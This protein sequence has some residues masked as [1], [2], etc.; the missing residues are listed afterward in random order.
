MFLKLDE[1]ELGFF[2]ELR[3][4]GG[5]RNI[6][7]ELHKTTIFLIRTRQG[8]FNSRWSLESPINLRL[9]LNHC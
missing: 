1:K 4:R 2:I 7:S 3:S 9:T 5:S 6:S 8:D